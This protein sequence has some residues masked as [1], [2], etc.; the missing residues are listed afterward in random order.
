MKISEILFNNVKPLW[1]EASDKEFV[2]QMAKGS[3]NPECFKKY[4]IQDYL[5]LYDYID[6]LKDIKALSNNVDITSF[7]EAIIK[8]VEEELKRVHVPNME[9]LG[10]KVDEITKSDQNEVFKKY[11]AYMKTSVKE[12][13]LHAGIITLLQCSWC[14]AYIAEKVSEKYADTLPSSAYKEWFDA[15]T[16]KAYTDANQI[17]IDTVDRE[18]ADIDKSE[19]EKM[20]EIFTEC[21]KYENKIWDTMIK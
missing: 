4:M 16:C 11:I 19:I 3:L 1:D 21:A 6:I 12:N 20:A 5:Y 7:I 14:Y 17:W 8:E 18:C 15:Y 2:L 13:G 10:I 9:N